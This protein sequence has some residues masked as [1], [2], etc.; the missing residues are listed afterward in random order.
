MLLYLLYV[1]YF[2]SASKMTYI[3]PGGALNFTHLHTLQRSELFGDINF[4]TTVSAVT[5]Y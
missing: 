4:M 2:S 5:S 3:M 1:I